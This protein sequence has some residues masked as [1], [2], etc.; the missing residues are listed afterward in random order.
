M[1]YAPLLG[2]NK[3]RTRSIQTL[4]N[5]RLYQIEVFSNE[6]SFTFN[7]CISKELSILPLSEKCA[8]AQVRCL[9]QWKN[10][11]CIISNL[12]RDIS[13]CRCH[14]WDKESKILADILDKFLSKKAITNF[15]LDRD[16]AGKLINAKAYNINKFVKTRD[17]LKLNFKYP[18]FSI[19]F[20]WVLRARCGYK[21]DARVTKAA[22]ND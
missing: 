8:I 11:N 2:S 13:R 5:S 19:G 20:R 9:K 4:V 14:A 16:M 12:L 1:Y 7:Y 15:Y 17:Y 3:E 22:K 6:N 18:E 10:S 21:F